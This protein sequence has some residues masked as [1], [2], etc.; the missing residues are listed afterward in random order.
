MCDLNSAP[1]DELAAFPGIGASRA[2]EIMLWRP[3][4][5]WDEVANVPSFDHEAVAQLRRHGA[6]LVVPPWANWTRT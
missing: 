5:D 1:L 6:M 3:Y 4:L 2:F